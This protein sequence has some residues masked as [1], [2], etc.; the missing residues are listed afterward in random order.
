M[1]VLSSA[2]PYFAFGILVFGIFS[3]F[4]YFGAAYLSATDLWGLHP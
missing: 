2:A 4:M 1:R 3:Y